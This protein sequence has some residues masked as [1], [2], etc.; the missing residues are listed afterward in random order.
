MWDYDFCTYRCYETII[1]R[2]NGNECTGREVLQK[3]NNNGRCRAVQSRSYIIV[4]PVNYVISFRCTLSGRALRVFM[5]DDS[6]C[7]LVRFAGVS[8]QKIICRHS[9][10]WNI[11][12]V[13]GRARYIYKSTSKRTNRT[14]VASVY[15]RCTVAE[16]R[17]WYDVRRCGIP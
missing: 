3:K 16:T 12:P 1:D 17:A 4:W 11:W 13:F 10:L 2:A 5:Y 6:I 7:T 14:H 8:V 9:W 15:L